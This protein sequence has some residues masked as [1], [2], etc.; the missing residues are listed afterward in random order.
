MNLV[1]AK[2][3]DAENIYALLFEV[4]LWIDTKCKDQ[5]PI[6]WLEGKKAEI[7]HSIA[8]GNFYTVKSADNLIAV[9]E[10]KSDSEIIWGHDTASAYYVHKLAVRRNC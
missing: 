3:C 1:P 7:F 8:T 10:V 6:E 2:N 9:V 5:W 4:A